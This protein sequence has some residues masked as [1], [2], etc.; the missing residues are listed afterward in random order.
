MPIKMKKISPIE[1]FRITNLSY[2]LYVFTVSKWEIHGNL[3]LVKQNIFIYATMRA[4]RA[5]E[6]SA[7]KARVENKN[8][9]A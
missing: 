8:L 7:N 5:L 6:I 4:F 3:K 2:R 9:A 1:I